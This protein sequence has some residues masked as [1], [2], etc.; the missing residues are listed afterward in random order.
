[1]V[2]K[3]KESDAMPRTIVTLVTLVLI[4]FIWS[5]WR[6]LPVFAQE[7][8][9]CTEDIANFC[10]DLK[11]GGGRIT[12]C[13]KKHEGQLSSLCNDKL[14]ERQ[15]RLDEA[16]RACTNDIEKFCRGVEPGEG[17]IAR[18][19][20]EHNPA[21]SPGCAEKLNLDKTKQKGK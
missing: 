11:P 1:M 13:L 8:R 5:A 2:R 20:E 3:M 9:P 6:T 7:T 10:K 4:I 18:C 16:K 19:L 21:L 17:R 15:R 12:T 14:Q